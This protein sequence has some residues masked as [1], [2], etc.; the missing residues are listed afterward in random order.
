MS[1]SV[2]A[3]QE[4]EQMIDQASDSFDKM[5][6]NV[7]TLIED[8]DQIDQMLGG[9]SE[10]NNQIVENIMHLSATT[11]EV[12]ASSVQSADL[13][14]QNLNNAENAKSLLGNVLEVSHQLDQYIS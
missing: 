3:A 2:E 7:N 5:N 4:Q 11:Q 6:G 14:M 10:A 13:S 9:L 12:T 8:I 1:R